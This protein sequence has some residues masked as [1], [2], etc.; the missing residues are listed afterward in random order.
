MNEFVRQ[1]VIESRELLEQAM[2]DLLVL[3]KSPH[4]RERLDG[5]FRAFHTLKGGASI[6]EFG[7]MERAVHAAETPL[8][9]ARSGARL[10]ARADI[11][12]CLACLD[13]VTRWLEAIE[14]AGEIPRDA[15]REA[16]SLVRRF[17]APTEI[18]KPWLPAFLD[19]HREAAKR[20]RC[21][22]RYSPDSESFFRGEDPL[23]RIRAFPGLLAVGVEAIAPWPA[24]LDAM[25]PFACN[26]VFNLLSELTA[27]EVTQALGEEAKHCEIA[28][29]AHES[30]L[31][32][33]ALAVLEAQVALLAETDERAAPGRLASAGLT[34]SNVLHSLGRSAQARHLEEVAAQRDPRLLAREISA[35]LAPAAAERDGGVSVGSA[36]H[37]AAVKTLR[38]DA[39]RIDALVRLAGEL[40]VAKNAM[41][42]AIKAS[43]AEM[44]SSRQAALER[45]VGELQRAVIALRVLP[46]RTTFQRFPRLVRE[47]AAELG[48]PATLVLEGEDTE[49]DKAIVEM[50]AEPLVHV[51]RNA[52]DH[53][54]E[55]AAARAAA[56]KPAMAT[57]RLTAAREGDQVIVEAT[58]DG[59]GIDARRVREVARAKGLVAPDALAEMTDAQALDLVFAP[60][61]STAASVT[62]LSGRGVGMDVVRTTVRRYGGQVQ[63]DTQPGKGTTV[64]F[65]LPFSIIVSQV[66]TVSAGGQTF[67]IPLDAVRETLRVPR[68]VIA[69]VGA[70]QAMVYRGRTVPLVELA[71]LLEAKRPALAR[72]GDA[73]VVMVEI[74][75]ELGALEVDGVGERMEVMLKPLEG[76][77]SGLPGIAGSTLLGDGSV[78]LVLDVGA[79]L[80]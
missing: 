12:N 26:V 24:S 36:Q 9:A 6:V 5:A 8:M 1:F 14:E 65:A 66:M 40:A 54:I 3:E 76:L 74:E 73:I 63:L 11:E 19:A 55:D 33:A 10:L 25:D 20:A 68:D 43:Q 28:V 30:D 77:L 35:A 16:A 75:G 80:Q 67:G 70:G 51:L 17:G 44:L 45:L 58:D 61:F 37:D 41:A 78:L 47:M 59:R 21:A 38:V 4:D 52:M 23:A 42:H 34:A 56:G 62:D 60:G 69:P 15:E 48:K 64:R 72:R 32:K 46:L 39:S 79:L 2:Q 57:I 27:S 50:L 13:Q 31:P 22:L 18:A 7:A 29:L 49:A 71:G 53:G